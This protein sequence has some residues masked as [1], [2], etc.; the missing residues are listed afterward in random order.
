MSEYMELYI[1]WTDAQDV[2]VTAGLKERDGSR[3]SVR[4][5]CRNV[6]LRLH[7]DEVARAFLVAA[8]EG[9]P[10]CL[11]DAERAAIIRYLSP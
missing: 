1:D 3:K 2:D 8:K 10:H 5:S 6:M 7:P 4:L 9:M 11:G